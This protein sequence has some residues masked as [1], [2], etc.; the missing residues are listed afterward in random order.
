MENVWERKFFPIPVARGKIKPMSREAD[1]IKQKLN[2]TDFLRSYLRLVPAGKNFKALCPFHQEKTP[3]FIVSPDRQTW[4]CFGC[5]EGGDIIKFVMR[6]ENF[7]FP[8]ALRLLAEKAGIPLRTLNPAQEREFGV[9]YDLNEEAKNFYKEG[10]IK[11]PAAKEYLL[12]RGLKEETIEEFEIGYAPAGEQL[13]LHLIKKGF[14]ISDVVRAGLA[15]KNAS[16]LYR[17]R[18][19]GRIIFPIANHMGKTVA[20]TGRVFEIPAGMKE[21]DL[22]KYMNSPETPVFNKSKILYGLNKTK[23]DIAHARAALLVEGQMDFLM[24]WQAGIKNVTA[25]SGTA[26][27]A[28]HLERLRRL[29][30]TILL[31]F[32]NDDAGLKALER[33]LDLFNTF[34]FHVKVVGIGNHKDPADAALADLGAF[35]K[36]VEEA[37]PAFQY[38]FEA[39]LKNP[40]VQKDLA[41][42]KRIVRDLL[43]KIRKLKSAVEQEDW[44]RAL[45]REAEVSE[46]ALHAELLAIPETKTE[47]SPEK[48]SVEVIPE[49]VDL[50][51]RRILSIGFAVPELMERARAVREWI[52]VFYHPALDDPASPVAAALEL[53]S[54]FAVE[55]DDRDILNE[56]FEALMRQLRIEA[57]E[58]ERTQIRKIIKGL[59]EKGDEDGIVKQMGAFH[60]LSKKIDELRGN[61]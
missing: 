37:R 26:L 8:E 36:G 24:T 28:H 52:P 55:T 14:D 54:S 56:E 20:F 5:G 61:K 9:L 51:T 50:I 1:L 38:L 25:V 2:V 39:R 32:D 42:K 4:H 23:N 13:A 30:D 27:T 12:K 47:E 17:D 7:E 44:L 11:K 40:A 43:Q 46:T 19:Q 16:G 45:S 18:F 48:K 53:Q 57:I 22:A 34:D 33:S 29:A 10:F 3:S 15:G 41:L 35:R 59:Q 49:R 21:S 6:Y 60:E 58:K 31:T